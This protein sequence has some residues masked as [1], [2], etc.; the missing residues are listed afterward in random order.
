MTNSNPSPAPAPQPV[1]VEY[2]IV[3]TLTK[4][5]AV[6]QCGS[7]LG[8]DEDGWEN[9]KRDENGIPIIPNC[10]S[11]SGANDDRDDSGGDEN[12][13]SWFHTDYK[14]NTV[15]LSYDFKTPQSKQLKN[16][17]IEARVFSVQTNP[18]APDGGEEE[19]GRVF[20]KWESYTV[21]SCTIYSEDPNDSGTWVYPDDYGAV[22]D[23]N[24]PKKY[25]GVI[26]YH[27]ETPVDPKELMRKYLCGID[28]GP[29]GNGSVPYPGGSA[30]SAY[31]Y[32]DVFD[33][34]DFAYLPRNTYDNYEMNQ[35]EMFPLS[36]LDLDAKDDRGF[37]AP[38]VSIEYRII[39]FTRPQRRG[40]GY[41]QGFT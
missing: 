24:H 21:T 36:P 14:W 16:F 38:L 11:S 27:E 29:S 2:G 18:P 20:R 34:S 17:N 4:G 30:R 28:D 10:S 41:I 33:Q 19:S 15:D 8:P 23:E 40:Y 13:L 5:N 26:L 37:A 7:M 9:M 3:W 31:N 32:S 1:I 39:L 25:G 35:S 22:V 6:Y 12:S